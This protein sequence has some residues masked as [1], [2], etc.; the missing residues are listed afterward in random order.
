[1][2]SIGVSFK[3]LQW[4]QVVKMDTYI[5][6]YDI[7][8]LLFPLFSFD[9]IA[10]LWMLH[11]YAEPCTAENMKHI[12]IYNQYFSLSIKIIGLHSLTHINPIVNNLMYIYIYI[13]NPRHTSNIYQYICIYIVKCWSIYPTR[14]Y[15]Y[16]WKLT[17]CYTH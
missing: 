17:F 13:H 3:R 2:H 1:M 15:I 5:Y 12:Y 10:S 7:Y 4:V 9:P 16:I 11:L 6:I 8:T 14:V